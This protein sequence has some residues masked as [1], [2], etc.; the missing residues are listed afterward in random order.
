MNS[1]YPNRIDEFQTKENEQGAS[2]D[3]DETTVQFAEDINKTN[4]AIVNVQETLGTNPNGSYSSVSDRLFDI[5][6]I[7]NQPVEVLTKFQL[8]SIK[9]QNGN[10]VFSFGRAWLRVGD[11]LVITPAASIS[12]PYDEGTYCV[13]ITTDWRIKVAFDYL[14][15]VAE[16]PDNDLG[17]PLA[18]FYLY[19]WE[20]KVWFDSSNYFSACRWQPYI[21][22]ATIGRNLTDNDYDT[23]TIGNA[24]TQGYLTPGMNY[25]ALLQ[26]AFVQAQDKIG[27]IAQ[28]DPDDI[29]YFYPDKSNAR[30]E[31]VM[32][33]FRADADGNVKIEFT[34]EN[35]GTGL[36]QIG[37][38]YYAMLP[39]DD[40]N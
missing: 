40:W 23:K 37:R 27:I 16:T 6:T 10:F 24:L 14:D 25:V 3:P 33:P 26:L 38:C 20:D 21:T 11:Q 22:S 31:F 19:Y 1:D 9:Y 18:E 28:G 5:E 34:I 32:I 12:I 30:A 2:Y 13:Y 4:E 15:G 8:K 39:I 35:P 29:I 17:I 7:A 36:N